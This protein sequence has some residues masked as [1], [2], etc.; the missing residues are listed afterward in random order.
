ME[1]TLDLTKTNYIK[2]LKFTEPEIYADLKG[3]KIICELHRFIYRSLLKSSENSNLFDG[4]SACLICCDLLEGSH[5][6]NELTISPAF[7]KTICNLRNIFANCNESEH[8]LA[9][10][11]LLLIKDSLKQICAKRQ[12]NAQERKELLENLEANHKK[13][14]NE[15]KW[16]CGCIIS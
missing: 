10:K 3:E 14:D 7:C 15:N 12:S 1:S 5:I 2:L 9:R 8:D 13:K 6:K 4:T 16:I 11:S